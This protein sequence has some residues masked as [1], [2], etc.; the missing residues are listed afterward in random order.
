M[1]WLDGARLINFVNNYC[2]QVFDQTKN[3][4]CVLQVFFLVLW[5]LRLLFIFQGFE[6]M[7]GFVYFIYLKDA[8]IKPNRRHCRL[9]LS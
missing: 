7:I 8:K 3:T 5:N 1:L 2:R 6:I 4:I 9:R